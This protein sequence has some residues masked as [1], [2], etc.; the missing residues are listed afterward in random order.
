M[1]LLISFLLGVVIGI[2]LFYVF[3]HY[4]NHKDDKIIF[5]NTK[6]IKNIDTLKTLDNRQK[7]IQEEK[8]RIKIVKYE[9]L[10][11]RYKDLKMEYKIDTVIKYHIDTLYSEI[12]KR[13]SIISLDSIQIKILTDKENLYKSNDSLL[14]SIND[15][16]QKDI[17][18]LDK[19][20][21]RKNLALKIITPIAVVSLL[22][23][24]L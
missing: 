22:L 15:A 6:Y 9:A 14:I 23:L 19:N 1:K 21:K 2:M 8:K 24:F 16:L 13:D 11:N 5:N 3:N 20:I 12:E 4:Y 10:N 7:I 18:K 17:D